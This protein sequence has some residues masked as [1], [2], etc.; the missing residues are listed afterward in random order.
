QREGEVIHVVADNLIDLTHLLRQ[1]G[2][3]EENL[4]LPN[5]CAD[6]T[7][8]NGAPDPRMPRTRDI[9]QPHVRVGGGL[10]V[11]SRYFSWINIAV[12]YRSRMAQPVRLSGHR[13][14]DGSNTVISMGKRFRALSA[15][16]GHA[17]WRGKSPGQSNPHTRW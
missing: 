14:M 2:E 1:I 9:P 13:R 5:T 15:F 3:R 8:L 7:R 17:M 10:T 16:R 4:R 12:G 6:E 11:K